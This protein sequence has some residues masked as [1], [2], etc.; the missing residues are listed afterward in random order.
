MRTRPTRPDAHVAWR[1]DAMVEDP[2]ERLVQVLSQ[3]LSR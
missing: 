1:S 3:I 2:A